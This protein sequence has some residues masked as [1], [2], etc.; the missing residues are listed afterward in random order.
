MV[1]LYGLDGTK[2]LENIFCRKYGQIR[3]SL[4]IKFG[5]VIMTKSLDI[6]RIYKN[7]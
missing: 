2:P 6:I 5:T 4:I 1:Y 3:W 7:D